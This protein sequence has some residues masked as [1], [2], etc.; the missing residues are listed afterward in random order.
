MASY[1]PSLAYMLDPLQARWCPRT[2]VKKI[3]E[4]LSELH[5]I[6]FSHADVC[7]PNICFNCEYEAILIDLDRCVSRNMYLALAMSFEE[8]SCMYSKPNGISAS[9]FNG[10]HLDYLQL[11][12]L[13]AWMLSNDSNYHTRT[14]GGSR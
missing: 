11:G 12:W 8:T 5:G 1:R 7:L 2:L 14:W 4:A 6:G 13:V 3:H 10:E 9:D